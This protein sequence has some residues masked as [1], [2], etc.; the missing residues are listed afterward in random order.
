VDQSWPTD[1]SSEPVPAEQ[2][3]IWQPRP[4]WWIGADDRDQRAQEA[5]RA[6][7]DRDQEAD[8]R[9]EA[10]AGREQD[11]VTREEEAAAWV[12]AAQRRLIHAGSEA[13]RRWADA[14]AAVE[15]ARTADESG[16]TDETR[17]ALIQAEAECEAE[18]AQI[19][20]SGIERH[21]VQDDLARAAQ[22][23]AASSA[24]RRAAAADRVR[25]HA[26]RHAAASD[27]AAAQSDRR[28]SAIDRS[29][30]SDIP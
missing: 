4:K 30:D 20:R 22:H 1:P 6:A 14:I 25:S 28:Q 13:A 15:A 10:A 26:D 17:A 21:S 24:D 7:R 11:A 3:A 5:D 9:D 16:S 8:T 2:Q 29:R 23:L 19:I 27:R 12:M 18:T